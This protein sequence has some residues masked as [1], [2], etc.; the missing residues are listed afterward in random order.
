MKIVVTG[1][2]G[3]IGSFLCT[4]LLT[5]GYDVVGID[6][7]MYKN[8]V[9]ALTVNLSFPNF[10]FVHSDITSNKPQTHKILRGADVLIHL[11][12]LVGE[13]ICKDYEDYATAVNYL[14][15]K[16][17][18]D[19]ECVEKII[20]AN[21]NSGYGVG[22]E[23]FCTE[24]TP[25]KPISHYGKTKCLAEDYIVNN[26]K[27]FYTILRLAT[28]FGLSHRQRFDLMV[29]YFIKELTFHRKL[30]IFEGNFRRNFVHLHDVVCVI[31]EFIHK[32]TMDIFNLGNDNINSTKLALAQLIASE[33]DLPY[34]SITEGKGEDTDKRDYIVSSQKLNNDYGL[35]AN[36]TVQEAVYGINMFCR[37]N[38]E[39]PVNKMGN[40]ANK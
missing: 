15:V 16:D 32:D 10:T 24:S 13:K 8:S 31:S 28:V 14:A 19:R 36:R 37:K 29:N 39:G 25:M 23:D 12:A 3:Y 27:G 33:L 20:F 9:E 4:N 21:T 30:E 2:A 22:G 7:L 40:Y 5:R 26:H 11:A 1:C 38:G 34:S 35:Y 17:I 18:V 6:N